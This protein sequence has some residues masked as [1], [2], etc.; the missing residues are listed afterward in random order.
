MGDRLQDGS[1]SGNSDGHI[2]QMSGKE[3]IIKVA[4]DWEAKVPQRV[5]EGVVGDRHSSFPHLAVG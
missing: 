5:E 3:E 4:Q 1:Q 2:Q